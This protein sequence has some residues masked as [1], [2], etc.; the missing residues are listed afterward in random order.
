MEFSGT[1]LG[2]VKANTFRSVRCSAKCS[3]RCIICCVRCFLGHVGGISSL[4]NRLT[5]HM[6][7]LSLGQI[8]LIRLFSLFCCG[9]LNSHESSVNCSPKV[10][11]SKHC[12]SPPVISSTHCNKM[13]NILIFVIQWPSSNY[14]WDHCL[15]YDLFSC[16]CILLGSRCEGGWAAEHPELFVNNARGTLESVLTLWWIHWV[17]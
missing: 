6:F 17:C 2:K 7:L 9:N 5:F 15:I 14:R 1:T 4:G 10:W 13:K 3:H 12:V 8:K 16:F 11:R